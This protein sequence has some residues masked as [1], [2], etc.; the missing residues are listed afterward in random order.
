MPRNEIK[1]WIRCQVPWGT[2]WSSWTCPASPEASHPT[3]GPGALFKL[4]PEPTPSFWAMLEGC[5][6]LALCP[7]TPFIWTLDR[8]WTFWLGGRAVLSLRTCL[9]IYGM[10]LTL[11]CGLITKLGLRPVSS[12]G[13]CLMLGVCDWSCTALL[14][15]PDTALTSSLLAGRRHALVKVNKSVNR[16]FLI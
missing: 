12:P 11:I 6:S 9:A 3:H 2:D 4:S 15:S 14:V 10:C 1:Q 8:V 5:C 7:C 13:A 16:V